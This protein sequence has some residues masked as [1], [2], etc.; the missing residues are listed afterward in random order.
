MLVKILIIFKLFFIN[1]GTIEEKGNLFDLAC[2]FLEDR[3]DGKYIYTTLVISWKKIVE[4][5]DLYDALI[6]NLF[7]D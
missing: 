5:I 6:Q 4:F 1:R 7:Q 3:I 2:Q